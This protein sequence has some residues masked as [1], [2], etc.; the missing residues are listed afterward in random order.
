MRPWLIRVTQRCCDFHD[1]CILISIE[2]QRLPLDSRTIVQCYLDSLRRFP[3]NV[4]C[5]QNVSIA[6]N[7]NAAPLRVTMLEVDR[8]EG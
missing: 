1:A 2:P 8:D 4:R 5:G 6:A 3:S 7:D